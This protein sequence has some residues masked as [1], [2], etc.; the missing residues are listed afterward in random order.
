M[1]PRKSSW[2]L[3]AGRLPAPQGV[4]LPGLLCCISAEGKA[5]PAPTKCWEAPGW[6]LQEE[7]LWERSDPDNQVAR[8]WG[9]SLGQC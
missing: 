7:L 4:P 6:H 8:I 1:A 9:P 5:G 2:F 3:V